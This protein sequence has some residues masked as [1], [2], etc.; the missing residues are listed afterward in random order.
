[1]NG[2]GYAWRQTMSLANEV[3]LS[4]ARR[5]LARL[6]SPGLAAAAWWFKKLQA[7]GRERHL[8]EAARELLAR[9]M[10]Y[11]LRYWSHNPFSVLG[12]PDQIVT[13]D[14]S[15][16]RMKFHV[17]P[18]S[19]CSD[20]VLAS[21]GRYCFDHGVAA[22][23]AFDVR[24]F[25]ECPRQLGKSMTVYPRTRDEAARVVR[26]LKALHRQRG[27]P[28]V[29]GSGQERRRW[30]GSL[31]PAEPLVEHLPYSFA[32]PRPWTLR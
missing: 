25:H 24:P 3:A 1:M 22:K 30:L 21:V 26:W 32:K 7:T 19:S 8:A 23:V 9:E 14:G 5:A 20:V 10:S 11:P 17:A 13:P 27:A 29:A 28:S 6:V 4:V 15:T 16:L 18:L 2:H 12:V 31:Q